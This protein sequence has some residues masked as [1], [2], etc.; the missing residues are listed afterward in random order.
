M[1]LG[2]VVGSSGRSHDFDRSFMPRQKHTRDR[3]L[4]VDRAYYKD[5]PLPPIELEQVG[6][7]YFVVDGH[8]RIS[9]ARIHGLQ[10]IEAHVIQ[11]RTQCDE[12]PPS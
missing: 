4:N 1:S 9:V 12:Y 10:Y 5:I 11:L 6:D 3:W 7:N 8:H 2:Q